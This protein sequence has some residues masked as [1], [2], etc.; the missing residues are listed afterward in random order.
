MYA[1]TLAA[2][3]LVVSV[4]SPHAHAQPEPIVKNG[5]VTIP[6]RLTPSDYLKPVSRAYLLPEYSESIPGNRVQMFL[7]CFMEQNAFFGQTESEQREKWNAAPLRD[8]PARLKDYGENLIKRD[9]YDAARMTQAD[10]QLWY[11]MCE[12]ATKPCSQMLRKCVNWPPP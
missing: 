7:R 6:I 3:T 1:R 10:W 12:M 5:R 11:F 8:L 2:T 9:M 4:L